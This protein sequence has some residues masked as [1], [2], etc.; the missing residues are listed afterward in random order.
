MGPELFSGIGSVSL[1]LSGRS[2][3]QTEAE[4]PLELSGTDQ[5]VFTVSIHIK[6]REVGVRP[7]VQHRGGF[8]AVVPEHLALE[9]EDSLSHCPSAQQELIRSVIIQI[10][11]SYPVEHV[12][13]RPVAVFLRLSPQVLTFALLGNGSPATMTEVVEH[14]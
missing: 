4:L 12:L 11:H 2:V 5:L 13:E 7:D 9:V 8:I 1:D 3:H 14:P 10:S 6:D